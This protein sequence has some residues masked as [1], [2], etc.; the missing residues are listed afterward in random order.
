[1]ADDPLPPDAFPP[2]TPEDPGWIENPGET[3]N[4][5]GTTITT[6][7]YKPATQEEKAEALDVEFATPIELG[8]DEPYPLDDPID[9]GRAFEQL[10]RMHSPM[11]LVPSDEHQSAMEKNLAAGGSVELDEARELRTAL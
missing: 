1:M 9:E 5:D 11:E 10:A 7:P 4:P 2:V 3:A 6:E 8:P